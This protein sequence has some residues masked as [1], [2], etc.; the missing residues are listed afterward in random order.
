MVFCH[1][2]GKKNTTNKNIIL[3]IGNVTEM[4]V[5]KTLPRNNKRFVYLKLSDKIYFYLI[6]DAS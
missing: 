4:K 3:G 2:L 1:G 6:G 5:R